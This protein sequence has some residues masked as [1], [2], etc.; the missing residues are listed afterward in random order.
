MIHSASPSPIPS[1]TSDKSRRLVLPFGG[2]ACPAQRGLDGVC[3]AGHAMLAVGEQVDV[4]GGPV[5]DAVR[6]EGVTAAEGKAVPGR[7]AQGDAGD[8]A[9]QVA[10]LHQAAASRAARSAGWRSSHARRSPL[11]RYSSGQ[12]AARTS[13]LR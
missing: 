10:D 4:G 11:G 13:P 12:T 1:N 5:D 2:V 9:V 8:L 7:R 3:G 6:D